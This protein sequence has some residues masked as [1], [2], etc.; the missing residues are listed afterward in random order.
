MLGSS[1]VQKTAKKGSKIKKKIVIAFFLGHPV[2]CR[3]R[4]YEW[5]TRPGRPKRFAHAGV[6]PLEALDVVGGQ[7]SELVVFDLLV[8]FSHLLVVAWI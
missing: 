3:K 1:E 4:T 5:E 7:N 2:H 6:W 8:E